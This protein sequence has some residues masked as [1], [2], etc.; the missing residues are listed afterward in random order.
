LQSAQRPRR[1]TSPI[2]LVGL[3][4]PLVG[5]LSGVWSEDT[6]TRYSRTVRNRRMRQCTISAGRTPTS[7]SRLTLAPC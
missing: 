4:A 5:T 7:R 2:R 3:F 6:A 1:F